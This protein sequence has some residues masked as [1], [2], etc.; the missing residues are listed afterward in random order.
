MERARSPEDAAA[1][2]AAARAIVLAHGED[3]VP[4]DVDAIVRA[5]GDAGASAPEL[6]LVQRAGD[7]LVRF[8]RRRA[9]EPAPPIDAPPA[10]RAPDVTLPPAVL[11]QMPASYFAG[12]D[13]TSSDSRLWQAM[14][15]YRWVLDVLGIALGMLL[16]WVS[17]RTRVPIGVQYNLP[18]AFVSRLVGWT[19]GLTFVSGLAGFADRA[20]MLEGP[21]FNRAGGPT[22]RLRFLQ[23]RGLLFLRGVLILASCVLLIAIG[24]SAFSLPGPSE[25]GAREE[26][27]EWMTDLDVIARFPASW[28]F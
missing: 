20:G 12:R 18:R 24:P 26:W 3:L 25:S 22:L 17:L 9:S 21:L 6:A 5:R 28:S 4:K 7:E 13:E 14:R 2:V 1:L 19:A 10:T 16:F 27:P 23:A 15:R 8:I 11:A